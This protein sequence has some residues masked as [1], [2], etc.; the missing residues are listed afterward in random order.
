MEGNL[1]KDFIQALNDA[2]EEYNKKGSRSNARVKPTHSFIANYLD[3]ILNKDSN[4]KYKI[5]SLG[6]D[7]NKEYTI[8]GKYY[9]KR[10]DIVVLVNDKP[11]VAISFK[12]VASNYAQNSNN[13]FEN[14]LG[15]TANIRLVNV[16]F[17]HL[18]ILRAHTPYYDKNLGNKRGNL[19]KTETLTEEHIEKYVKL[20]MDGDYPHKPDVLGIL[21]VD[22]DKN[23]EHLVKA[24]LKALNFK[25]NIIEILEKKLSV[26]NFFEKVIYL[27]RLR[28][29]LT[30]QNI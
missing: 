25:D 26:N 6:V 23:N 21:I 3:S 22:D 1:E 13:Y 10:E 5:Y 14:L 27:C 19:I 8:D 7:D 16:G 20:F 28:S 2:Y 4:I 30:F 18:L 9:P 24:D 15:E 17:A 29:W 11:I 12:F